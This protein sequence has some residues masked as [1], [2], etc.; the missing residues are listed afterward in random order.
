MKV[1]RLLF[2]LVASTLLVSCGEKCPVCGS[3]PGETYFNPKTG[4]TALVCSKN[5]EHTWSKD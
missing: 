4:R 2:L 3:E 1:A 5:K